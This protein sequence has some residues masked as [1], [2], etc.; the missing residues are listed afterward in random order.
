M[1]ISRTLLT[2]EFPNVVHVFPLLYETEN[3]PEEFSAKMEWVLRGFLAM[4]KPV[5]GN[6]FFHSNNCETDFEETKQ[7]QRM[8]SIFIERGKIYFDST[9]FK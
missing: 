5:P 2:P 7:Q 1:R 9:V 6:F 4:V 3:S 8:N